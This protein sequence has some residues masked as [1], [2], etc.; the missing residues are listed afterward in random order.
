MRK[1]YVQVNA[2]FSS[3]GELSPKSFVWDDG[4]CYEIDRV[5]DHKLSASLKVG[6]H[7]IRYSCRVMGKDIFLFFED[8]RWFI[9]GK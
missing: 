7:G 9:E 5:Y 1:V 4:R 6:G 8:S 2:V 3:S